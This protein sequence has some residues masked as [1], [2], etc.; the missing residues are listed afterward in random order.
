MTAED[1][2]GDKEAAAI[3][4]MAVSTLRIHCM[5]SH[6]CRKGT[7]DVRLACPVVVGKKRRWNRNN[8]FDLLNGAGLC[9]GSTARF[10]RVRVGSNPA[11][12][13]K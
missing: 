12:A 9:N 5:K 7:V 2:I 13:T 11:P 1:F 4:G 10:E 3:F 6:V 8:I